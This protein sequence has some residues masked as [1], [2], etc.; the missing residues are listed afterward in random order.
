MPWL[1]PWGLGKGLQQLGG[2]IE[3]SPQNIHLS[4]S[5]EPCSAGNQ[6]CRALLPCAAAVGVPGHPQPWG[7]ISPVGWEGKWVCRESLGVVLGLCPLP[8]G[9]MVPARPPGA[10]APLGLGCLPQPFIA[11]QWEAPWLLLGPV[12]PP[13]LCPPAPAGSCAPGS[14]SSRAPLRPGQLLGS[15]A[16]SC[17]TSPRLQYL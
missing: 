4:P 15:R 8:V 5:A 7:M 16:H 3:Q 14:P 12:C 9:L 1:W 10:A 11:E 6:V 17:S 2:D 13:V